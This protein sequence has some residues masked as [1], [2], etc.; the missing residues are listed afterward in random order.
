MADKRIRL[1]GLDLDEISLVRSGDDPTAKTLI[2]KAE[3]VVKCGDVDHKDLKAGA[4]CPDCGYV[5]KGMPTGRDLYVEE[6]MARR[7]KKRTKALLEKVGRIR[8][9]DGDG[10]YSPRRGMPDKTPVPRRRSS[11]G[12][13]SMAAAGYD[14]VSAA[15]QRIEAS[16]RLGMSIDPADLKIVAEAERKGK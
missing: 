2:H 5:K 1:S 10:M 13:T 11:S 4:T 3:P 6:A 15:K 12:R 9:G 16:K 7:R 8:D 14:P